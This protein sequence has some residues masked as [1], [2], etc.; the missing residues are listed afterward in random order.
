MPFIVVIFTLIFFTTI[1]VAHEMRDHWALYKNDEVIYE[2]S[3]QGAAEWAFQFCAQLSHT[4]NS[5]YQLKKINYRLGFLWR[6]R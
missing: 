2:F 3:T 6:I 1:F 4:D 5:T